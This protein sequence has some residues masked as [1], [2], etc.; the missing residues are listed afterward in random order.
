[1]HAVAK[2]GRGLAVATVLGWTGCGL[3]GVE[4]TSTPDS[5]RRGDPVTFGVKITNYSQCPT[6]M[7]IVYLLPFLP[8]SE[9]N[10]LLGPIPPD[11]PPELLE[12]VE[13]VREFFDVLCS[14]GMPTPPDLGPAPEARSGGSCRRGNGEVVCRIANALPARLENSGSMTL[15][16]LGDRLRCRVDAGVVTCEIHLPLPGASAAASATTSAMVTPLTCVTG[17]QIGEGGEGVAF[18]FVGTLPNLSGLAPREMAVGQ[19]ALNARG[20]GTVRNLAIAVSGD[21]DDLGVCKGGPDAGQACDRFDDACPS[22]ACGEGICVG[23]N[24]DGR[25]CDKSSE[26]ADCPNGGTCVLCADVPD[27][28]FLPIDC[29]TTNV[30]AEPVPAM[31]PSL[32]GVLGGCL[33]AVGLWWLRRRRPLS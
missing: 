19:I 31:S 10:N 30:A 4:L 11:A 5:V 8:Q 12:V 16:G 20:A 24:N 6:Q 25:G 13:L 14:G 15:V 27:D 3:V 29:T 26:M 18:C 22:S 21:P 2:L 32:L 17:E 33:A 28:T 1:M 9:F 23:G 7:A